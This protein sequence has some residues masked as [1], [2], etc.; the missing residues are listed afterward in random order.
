VLVLIVGT[1]G[2]SELDYRSWVRFL[3]GVSSNQCK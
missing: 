1:T 3:T 2:Y